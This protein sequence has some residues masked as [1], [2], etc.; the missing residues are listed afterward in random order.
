VVFARLDDRLH[1]AEELRRIDRL[2]FTTAVEQ[3]FARIVVT[4]MTGRTSA[5]VP[6][7]SGAVMA[8]CDGWY[9]W[10]VPRLGGTKLSK[11]GIQYAARQSNAL[12]EP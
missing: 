6:Q 8:A 3:S 1:V 9:V 11:L 10:R 5:S 2:R 4:L 12:G 7:E